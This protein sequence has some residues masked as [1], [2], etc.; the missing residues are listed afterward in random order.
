MVEEIKK[1]TFLVHHADYTGLLNTLRTAGVVHIVQKRKLDETSPVSRELK[2]LKRYKEAGRQLSALAPGVIPADNPAEPEQAL[3]EFNSL[4][5]DI[6]EARHKI[7][8]LG[9]EAEKSGPW[10]S[11]DPDTIK[12]LEEAGWNVSLFTCPEKRFK[13][14]WKENYT[15]EIIS[16]KRGRL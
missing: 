14:E 15:L 9:P 16:R 3:N 10:G 11:F 6:E 13:E 12:K 2:S 7:E 4:L 8:L 1:Y 5:S